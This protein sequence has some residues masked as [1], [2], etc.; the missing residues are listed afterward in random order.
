MASA[1]KRREWREHPNARGHMAL[2]L[3]HFHDGFL[4]ASEALVAA[5]EARAS[6]ASLRRHFSPLSSSLHH[7]HS[8]EEAVLFP[9]LCELSGSGN[10]DSLEAD[11]VELH[12][13]IEGVKT[14]L[15]GDSSDE[16]RARIAVFDEVLRRHLAAEEDF[17]VPLM[18]SLSASELQRR[19]H[20]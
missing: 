1:A 9:L 5:A 7:H 20:H 12:A 4:E 16:H 3:L 14:A 10:T 18:L 15:A 8:I 2:M 11:H 19:L 17:S 6:A 13:A